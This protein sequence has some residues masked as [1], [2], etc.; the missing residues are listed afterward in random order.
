MKKAL[1]IADRNSVA[2]AI[3]SVYQKIRNTIPYDITITAAAGPLVD[4]C[5]PKE[6]D[7][8]WEELSPK[9]KLPLFP[10][11]WK[12]KV[13]PYAS[14]YY[15]NIKALWDSGKYEIIINAGDPGSEGQLIQSYIYKSIGVNVPI[16]RLWINDL[17]FDSIQKGL[18]NLK[19]NSE[20]IKMEHAAHLRA[21]FDWLVETNYTKAASLSL[22]R[23]V[24]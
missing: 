2:R 4:L 19:D 23:P 18:E 24:K 22:G 20:F 8:T 14:K 21:Y 7:N 13:I 11:V 10:E 3:N 9:S 6:Y 17:S 1:L 5:G 12:T 16:L 15:N